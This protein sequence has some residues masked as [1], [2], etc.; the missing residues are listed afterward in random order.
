MTRQQDH[1]SGSGS[2]T[3]PASTLTS[4]FS[5]YVTCYAQKSAGCCHS[6]FTDQKQS[7]AQ[8][9]AYRYGQPVARLLCLSCCHL[10]TG[11]PAVLPYVNQTASPVVSPH[12]LPGQAGILVLRGLGLCWYCQVLHPGTLH[13]A[14]ASLTAVLTAWP[15]NNGIANRLTLHVCRLAQ[16]TTRYSAAV[17]SRRQRIQPLLNN[18]KCMR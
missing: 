2:N 11:G 9:S 15:A 12:L 1:S 14:A 17:S 4:D 5:S 13:P 10:H 3:E 7:S 18:M 16:G 6:S 8:A